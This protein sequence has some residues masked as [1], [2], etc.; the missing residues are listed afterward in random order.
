M[1]NVAEGTIS[2]VVIKS[3]SP[4]VR[5]EEIGIAIV[6]VI[7]RGHP[8]AYAQFRASQAGSGGD[9][10][11][12]AVTFVS[13]QPIIETRV[14]FLQTGKFTS[15]GEENIHQPVAIEI[16]YCD[17]AA[18]GLGKVFSTGESVM[19]N[20]RDTGAGGCICIVKPPCR[21][22]GRTDLCPRQEGRQPTHESS[23]YKP[24][25]SCTSMTYGG[26]VR[27]RRMSCPGESEDKSSRELQFSRL[28][29]E[30]VFCNH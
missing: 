21:A 28:V 10:L 15:V 19:G 16:Q 27:V 20:V 24:H 4:R 13:I 29:V 3:V 26:H 12:S 9:I 25:S 11:K 14:A 18:H 1:G 30:A 6:V 23:R 22:F 17:S 7:A 5:Y 2:I 8:I